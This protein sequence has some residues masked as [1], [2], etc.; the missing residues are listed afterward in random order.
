MIPRLPGGR[1]TRRS[2]LAAGTALIP[3]LARGQ[4]ADQAGAR[5][6]ADRDQPAAAPMGRA[7]P[8]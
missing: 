3:A 7:R 8:S 1:L 4:T 5:G 6:P 2:L